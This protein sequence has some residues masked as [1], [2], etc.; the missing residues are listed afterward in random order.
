VQ[1]SLLPKSN[2]KQKRE[3]G[4]RKKEEER[5]KLSYYPLPIPIPN[6]PFLSLLYFCSKLLPI[7][8]A[9]YNGLGACDKLDAYPTLVWFK[10]VEAYL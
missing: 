3:E 1:P 9:R 6:S 2:Q 7:E 8:N 4:R 10:C 5:R